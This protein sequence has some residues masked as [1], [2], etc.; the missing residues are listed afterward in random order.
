[1]EV[2]SYSHGDCIT[3]VWLCVLPVCV[4]VRVL[5]VHEESGK[6]NSC[7]QKERKKH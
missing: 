4:C 2:V 5:K 1:M 6:C 7:L 3:G